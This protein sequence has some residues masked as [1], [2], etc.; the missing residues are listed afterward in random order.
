MASK[1]RGF[2][3]GL[4]GQ[5]Y[6]NFQAKACKQMTNIIFEVFFKVENISQINYL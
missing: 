4:N 5:G 6:K 2:I 3:E 1:D